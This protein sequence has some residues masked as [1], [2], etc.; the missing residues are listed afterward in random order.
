LYSISS[1]TNSYG[2]QLES[3][4]KSN[5]TGHLF[6]V[7]TIPHQVPSSADVNYISYNAY[8]HLKNVL[9]KSIHPNNSMNAQKLKGTKATKSYLGVVIITFSNLLN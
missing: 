4:P 8:K 5:G 7:A 1:L 9:N 6:I 3:F 2:L